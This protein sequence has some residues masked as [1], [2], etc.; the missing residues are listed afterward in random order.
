MIPLASTLAYV[1]TSSAA[2]WIPLVIATAALAGTAIAWQ[3]ERAAHA[4]TRAQH[5]AQAERQ[6]RD[7]LRQIERGQQAAD[8]YTTAQT[9]AKTVYKTITIEVDRIITRDVYRAQ[10]FDADGLRQL[11]AAINTGAPTPASPDGPVPATEPPH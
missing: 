1:A 9:Y 5:A 11:A 3:A 10:C 7:T 6:A 8:T 2:R 4:H